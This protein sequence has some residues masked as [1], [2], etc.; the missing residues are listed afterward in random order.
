MILNGFFWAK[1]NLFL[2]DDGIIYALHDWRK[3]WEQ[4][5]TVNWAFKISSFMW[6]KNGPPSHEGTCHHMADL[7]RDNGFPY[8]LLFQAIKIGMRK[9]VQA[10][11]IDMG[12]C[13]SQ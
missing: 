2:I 1:M 12:K 8:L 7:S 4:C 6:W 9:C 11:K 13:T 3:F 10:I 5:K